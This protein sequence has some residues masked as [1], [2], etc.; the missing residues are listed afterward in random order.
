MFNEAGQDKI[1]ITAICTF[2]KGFILGSSHGKFCLWIKKEQGMN[3][4][5][6]KLELVRKWATTEERAAAVTGI[7]INA[8]EDLLAISLA[9]N[10]I[11][12]IFLNELLPQITDL[13]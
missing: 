11:T 4:E 7:A 1:I 9:N 5:E 3:F 8:K 2:S 12:T 13:A 6:E 10:D